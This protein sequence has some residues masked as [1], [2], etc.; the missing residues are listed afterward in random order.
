MKRSSATL[1]Q[2]AREALNGKYGSII[3]GYLL[4][5]LCSTVPNALVS[6]ILDTSN[7]IGL[8]TCQIVLYMISL[9]IALVMSGFKY[10]MLNINRRKIFTMG[11]LFY[12][13]SH[14][15]D[16][17]LVV[18]L[19]FLLAEIAA[20]LPFTILSYKT[21]AEGIG[22][23]ILLISAAGTLASTLISFILSLFFGMTE[24][25]LLDNEN[26]GA[27]E[28]LREALHMMKGNKGRFFYINLSF[29][30]LLLV[31]FFTC[32]L[33][34]L[35]L[36]PYM[37]ATFAFFYMELIGELDRPEPIPEEIL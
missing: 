33:G 9:L 21:P 24:Y 28:A 11:D 29:L 10:I 4:I 13:F 30:P 31:C 1:K 25:L 3:T 20:S 18:N 6:T 15:P 37:Q 36:E 14:H 26:M 22:T 19:I 5:L 17:F 2:L 8:I 12:A 35:W 7:A 27:M 34:L 23:N 16:R 32:Y